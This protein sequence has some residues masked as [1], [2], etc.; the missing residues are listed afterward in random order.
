MYLLIL[1]QGEYNMELGLFDTIEAGREFAA[2][3]PGYRC[4][5]EEGEF[6]FIYES[7]RLSDIPNYVEVEYM[8]NILPFSRFSFPEDTDIDIYWKELPV[9]TNKGAGMIDG[10]TR[11]DAYSIGN[12][13]VK[14]YIESREANFKKVKKF[15]ADRGYETDRAFFGSEDGEAILYRKEGDSD[16]RF[17]FH[18]D[19]GFSDELTENDILDNMNE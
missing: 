17:L 12:Y 6:E 15:L 18:M 11:V 1:S 8:G 3:L 9:L 5:I 16:W 10:A 13:E 14:E 2:K 19:P 7:L 4:E